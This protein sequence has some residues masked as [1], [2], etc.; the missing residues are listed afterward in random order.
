[1][2]FTHTVICSLIKHLKVVRIWGLPCICNRW[3][4]KFNLK[5][6]NFSDIRQMFH[7]KQ[8]LFI[9]ASQLKFVNSKHDFLSWNLPPGAFSVDIEKIF[10]EENISSRNPFFIKTVYTFSWLWNVVWGTKIDYLPWLCQSS[11]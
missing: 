9:I 6:I 2:P 8:K 5:H 3:N 10:N 1:M 7:K 11:V 4:L